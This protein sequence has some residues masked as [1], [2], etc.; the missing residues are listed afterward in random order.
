MVTTGI[1]SYSH[2]SRVFKRW[3]IAVLLLAVVIGALAVSPAALEQVSK[4]RALKERGV[5][6]T[7]TVVSHQALNGKRNCGSSASVSYQV[8]GNAYAIQIVGCGT[9]ASRLPLRREVDVVY[10]PSSPHV[11][12]TFLEEASVSRASAV[13]VLLL[14]AV[15]AMLGFVAYRSWAPKQSRSS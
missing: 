14:W 9:V 2:G 3:A 15:V 1:D 5:R 6:T 4:G 10:L 7:G 8:N 11:A 12:D 13:Q